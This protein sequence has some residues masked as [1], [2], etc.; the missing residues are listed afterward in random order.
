M[1]VKEI[2]PGMVLLNDA[3]Q[4]NGRVLLKAGSKLTENNIR[5]FKT[6]G[7]L[8]VDIQT[9]EDQLT[10]TQKQHSADEI[11]AMISKKR[12]LF[13]HCDLKHPWISELF[14]SSVKMALEKKEKNR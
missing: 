3:V 8:S 11:K 7:V 1:R 4:A 14:R 13:R 2:K 10:P 6:W 12:V 9:E 5:I